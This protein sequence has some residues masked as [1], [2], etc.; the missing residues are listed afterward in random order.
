[1]ANGYPRFVPWYAISAEFAGALLLIP[2]IYTRWVSLY[3][4]PLTIGASHDG[5]PKRFHF[6]V[7]D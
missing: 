7:G 4:L 2:G 1:L 3:A 6:Q 5:E